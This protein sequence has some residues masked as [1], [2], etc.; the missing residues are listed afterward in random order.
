MSAERRTMPQST[1]Q[2]LRPRLFP[3]PPPDASRPTCAHINP[4]YPAAHPTKPPH[5]PPTLTVQSLST[6][7]LGDLRSLCTMAG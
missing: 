6:S 4:L 3:P 5:P 7:R 1:H 2:P